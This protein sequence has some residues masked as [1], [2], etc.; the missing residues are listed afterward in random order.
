MGYE[1]EKSSSS[2][3]VYIDVNRYLYKEGSNNKSHIVVTDD[4]EVRVNSHC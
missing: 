2:Y 3:N 4:V 1:E